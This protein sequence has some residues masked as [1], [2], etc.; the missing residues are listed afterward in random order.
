MIEMLYNSK[1][2]ENVLDIL[3]GCA[4][5]QSEV[6]ST[7]EDEVLRSRIEQGVRKRLAEKLKKETL[8][9]HAIP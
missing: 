3:L 1:E 7:I 8:Q 4:E 2:F 9:C 5:K 6:T